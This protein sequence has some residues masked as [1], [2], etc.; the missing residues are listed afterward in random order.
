[1]ADATLQ[2]TIIKSVFAGA[3]IFAAIFGLV[4]GLTGI[5]VFGLSGVFGFLAG[6]VLGAV[7]GAA[8]G[9][10][11]ALY[12]MLPPRFANTVTAILII[13]GI[14]GLVLLSVVWW[15]A[16]AFEAFL[17]PLGISFD[18]ITIGIQ[19]GVRCM[20]DPVECFFKPFYDW[21]EPSVTE[22]K[23]SQIRYSI[24]TS[25]HLV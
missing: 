17:G 22:N 15:R 4:F 13:G 19:K 11:F 2:N 6:I 12:S 14:I 18:R 25:F 7:V 8:L 5:S 20:T 21:S 16:G 24:N 9:L 1:M 10:F 23:V 3:L